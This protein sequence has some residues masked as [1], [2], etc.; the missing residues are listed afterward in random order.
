MCIPDLIVRH[1]YD[2]PLLFVLLCSCRAADRSKSQSDWFLTTLSSVVQVADSDARTQGYPGSAK[3]PLL[4][5]VNA[6]SRTALQV[7]TRRVTA[8]SIAAALPRGARDAVRERAI[9]CKSNPSGRELRFVSTLNVSFVR[10]PIELTR[11]AEHPATRL[12]LPYKLLLS[13]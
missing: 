11:N 12:K 1:T 8:D 7:G 13:S 2:L 3:G 4:V 6:L 5:D 10:L 9:V